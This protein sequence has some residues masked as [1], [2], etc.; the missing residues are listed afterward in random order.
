MTTAPATANLPALCRDNLDQLERIDRLLAGLEPGDY[1]R[2]Q[3][4]AD[5]IGRHV[6]HV[7]EHYD[8]LLQGI[9]GRID[10]ET[11]ARDPE[12]EADPGVARERIAG[13]RDKLTVLPETELPASI[14]VRYTSACGDQVPA[15]I[16]S[17]PERECHFVLSHT[18]HHMALIAVLAQ[19]DGHG[20]SEDFG[21]AGSTLRYRA[22]SGA[23]VPVAQAG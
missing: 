10:Y 13:L 12:V 4:C 23:S 8:S 17:T 2:E 14:R 18:V 5:P 11:R 3:L 7:L 21:V 22:N 9:D 19:R 16:D 20:V 6:R 1:T 15:D